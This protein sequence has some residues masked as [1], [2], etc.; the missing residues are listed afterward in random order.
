MHRPERR[1][2]P[3]E[4]QREGGGGPRQCETVCVLRCFKS[5]GEQSHKDS[6][7]EATVEEQLCSKTNCPAMRAQLRFPVLDLSWAFLV[8]IAALPLKVHRGRPQRVCKLP[9]ERDTGL[10]QSRCSCGIVP[11]LNA[12]GVTR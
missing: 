6:V 2:P 5:C 7:R 12:R 4:Q 11:Q 9:S 10:L 3:P 1:Q 8:R